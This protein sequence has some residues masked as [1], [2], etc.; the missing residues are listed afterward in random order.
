[1]GVLRGYCWTYLGVAGNDCRRRKERLKDLCARVFKL[2]SKFLVGDDD[3]STNGSRTPF[4]TFCLSEG[5]LEVHFVLRELVRKSISET[6]ESEVR[7]FLTLQREIAGAA[8]EALE[9]FRDENKKT[10]IRLVDM[11]S[12][13]LIVDFFVCSR[14]KWIR[15]E[16]LQLLHL[17]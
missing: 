12:L 7:H 1:M 17:G 14:K 2:V 13:Y 3:C 15:V 10:V 11:E 6:Q 5:C 16:T 4:V 9:K 8:N